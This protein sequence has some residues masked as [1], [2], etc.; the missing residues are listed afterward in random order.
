MI[1]RSAATFIS[2][3]VCTALFAYSSDSTK[4]IDETG[5]IYP[6]C[7]SLGVPLFVDG[8]QVGVSPL[9][10]PVPVLAG[11]HEIG[12]A[13][14]EIRNEYVKSRLHH[15]IKK[16]YVPIGDTVNVALSFDHEYTQFKA[17]RTEHKI[18]QYIGMMM[19]VAALYLFWLIS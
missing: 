8:I 5:Y 9:R 1:L 11:F 14:P 18:T 2:F 17:L 10:H 3:I 19:A 12:Y 7:D 6:T 15:A 13:P 16:V 4:V